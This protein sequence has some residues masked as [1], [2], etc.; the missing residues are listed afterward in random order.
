MNAPEIYIEIGQSSLRLLAGSAGLE[1][2][3]ERLENGRITPVCRERLTASVR[4]FLKKHGV[5]PGLR[6]FCAIG[7]RGV[8]LR[9]LTLPAASKEELERLLLLQIEREFPLSPDELAWGH[10]ALRP[11][12]RPGNGS[13]RTQELL[14]VAVKK[15]SL[16][17]YADILFDCGLT[18]LFTLGALARSGLVSQPPP[19]Y[20]VLDI[21]RS[22]SELISF[23]DGVPS[24]IR[25]IAWGEQS[26]AG[27]SE[28][29]LASLAKSLPTNSTG[30]KL[31]LS[32]AGV[33]LK[34][35]VPQLAK[36]TG[37]G[38]ECEVIETASG[39][40]RSAAILGLKKSCEEDGEPPLILANCGTRRLRSAPA[41]VR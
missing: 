7:A 17:E 28:A 21:G 40:G 35:L 9:R 37:R 3:L 39:E 2:P 6:A 11:E 24:S 18:P 36:V 31:Y 27:A 26:I 15:E 1:A 32:G 41:P 4:E 12:P 33:D 19:S 8:S 38:V 29:E 25:V 16:Q 34:G 20:A 23:E 13:A 10:R 5:R 14:V 22:H 30:Q